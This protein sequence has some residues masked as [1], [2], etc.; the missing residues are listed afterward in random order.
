MYAILDVN[1][2]VVEVP[3]EVFGPWFEKINNRIVEKAD[4]ADCEVS[5]VFL[6]I[7][8]SFK[9]TKKLWFE[10]MIFGGPRDGEQYRYE[11]YA[12]AIEGHNKILEE[13][14]KPKTED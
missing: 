9:S 12:E 4:L 6:G 7:D 8:H 2:N 5:T 3:M 14:N 13:L 10:T 1:K 11:T